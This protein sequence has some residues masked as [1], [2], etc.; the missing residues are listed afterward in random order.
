VIIGSGDIA[1]ALKE[2]NLDRNDIIFFA[3]GVS[4]SSETRRGEFERE[5]DLM[6]NS[7]RWDNRGMISKKVH[8]VYF[9]TLSIYYGSS[10]YVEHKKRMEDMFR[11]NWQPNTTIVRIGNITWGKNPNTLL[12]F[13]RN[14][15]KNQEQVELQDTYRYL[16]TELEFVHWIKLIPVGVR[17][18]MNIP[19][20]MMHV[21]EIYEQIKLGIL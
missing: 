16:L 2:N 9:S 1:T 4:N 11:S 21:K 5:E 18:E 7:I 17:N 13:F 3:S 19:G 10:R 20:T 8:G 15:I 14:K 12:N 6:L